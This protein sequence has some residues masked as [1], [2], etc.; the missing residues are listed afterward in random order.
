MD[1]L[2]LP[3]EVDATPFYRWRNQDVVRENDMPKAIQWVNGGA[4]IGTQ[5]PCFQLLHFWPIDQAPSSIGIEIFISRID[6]KVRQSLWDVLIL[7][8][9]NDEINTHPSFEDLLLLKAFT[10]YDGEGDDAVFVFLWIINH[11]SCMSYF[12]T[13]Y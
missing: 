7:F 4:G 6:A 12:T 10:T 2:F 5:K 8:L 1:T 3:Y 11:P 13:Q 9:Q